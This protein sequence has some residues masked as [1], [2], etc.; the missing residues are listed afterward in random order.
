[1][2]TIKKRRCVLQ[3]LA[4]ISAANLTA[5]GPPG[6]RDLRKGEAL[7]ES[8]QCA[9]AIPI[10]KEG[11]QILQGAQP[12]V[13]ASALNL[14]GLAYQGAGK[15]EDASRAYL[16][17]LKLDRNL[18][19]LDFNLGCL[20]LEQTNF[21]GAIDY[22]TTYTTSHPKDF[23]GFLMLG[24]ARLNLALEHSAPEKTRQT[25][26][27]NA[28]LDFEYAEQL[29]STA[30]GCNALGMIALL[31][32]NPGTE[33]VKSSVSFFKHALQLEPH[34]PPA[35]LNLAIV[36]QTYLNEPREALEK[37]REYLALQPVPPQAKEVEKVAHQLDLSL[38]IIISPRGGEHSSAAP[39]A[40][41]NPVLPRQP[42]A[43]VENPVPRPSSAP[44][45]RAAP[46]EKP[47][48][49]P[50]V[51]AP[52]ANPPPAII[53]PHPS[54]V[55]SPSVPVTRTSP[56][57]A[58]PNPNPDLAGA[59]IPVVTVPEERK[60][61]LGRKLNPLNW[62]SGKPKKSEAAETSVPPEVGS[63]ERYTYPLPVTPIPGD[64]KLAEQWISEG[65]QAERQSN[66]AE[67]MRD[68]QEAMKA[69]PTYYEAG[70]ALGLAAID[71]KDYPTA[72]DAL[73]QAL[74]VQANSA[75]ARYAFAWVLGKR[76]YYHDAANEL[77]KVLS[78]HPR[79]VRAR[80]LL[81]NFYADNL[82]QPKLAR[83]QYVKALDLIEPQSSQAAI[84]RAWLEQH[85]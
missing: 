76:G 64:R 66:R 6:A 48:V 28:R 40:P 38:R 73:G 27:E 83:E 78:A 43:P 56:P 79:E 21:F 85:P 34:Y 61:G 30:E 25:Q 72:L 65:R 9:E 19:A 77:V 67:A 70:L 80:L 50:Q 45:S 32:R 53:P 68:Y 46:V 13:R 49:S 10:L 24:R 23:N 62:F 11:L 4:V 8:G 16:E 14:L 81:G 60:S 54:P 82:G 7:I 39:A 31:R 55:P 57:S 2:L 36:L 41:T 51:S 37:Y 22:L 15:L 5:C 1:M 33:Q 63:S 59:E 47:A 74:T 75:D 44:A 69:D 52:P 29:H 12:N 26:L 3:V 20:R 58:A 71:A 42:P 17:A 18:W 84:I 35:L